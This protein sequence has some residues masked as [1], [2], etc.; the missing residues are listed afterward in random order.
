MLHV[1]LTMGILLCIV[2]CH[3]NVV[4]ILLLCNWYFLPVWQPVLKVIFFCIAISISWS[5][6]CT[7]I[8][9]CSYTL[10]KY[11]PLSGLCYRFACTL[12]SLC[13]GECTVSFY[14][15]P[16]YPLAKK[17]KFCL[18]RYKLTVAR[19]LCMH[20]K[21]SNKCYVNVVY[22]C[23]EYENAVLQKLTCPHAKMYVNKKWELCSFFCTYFVNLCWR[24]LCCM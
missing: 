18:K 2:H 6:H 5:V 22:W 9:V 15:K 13:E 17:K 21:H 14:W 11:N 1:L 4:L 20:V 12:F 7:L 24:D 19:L 8:N 3:V 23:P 16:C 10:L